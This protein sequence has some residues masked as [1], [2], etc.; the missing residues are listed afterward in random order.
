MQGAI[1][2][3]RILADQKMHSFWELNKSCVL[4]AGR[5]LGANKKRESCPAAEAQASE[6]DSCHNLS[7]SHCSIPKWPAVT[8]FGAWRPLQG[9]HQQQRQAYS[10]EQLQYLQGC[11]NFLVQ[12]LHHLLRCPLVLG[13]LPPCLQTSEQTNSAIAG[14]FADIAAEAVHGL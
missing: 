12:L 3:A 2:T 5:R 9:P 1:V 10:G 8:D 6:T 11:S 14:S 13:C 4:Q 7:V